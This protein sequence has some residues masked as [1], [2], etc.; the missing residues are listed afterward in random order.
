MRIRIFSLPLVALLLSVASFAQDKPA[1]TVANTTANPVPTKIVNTTP[2]AVTGTVQVGNPNVNVINTPNVNVANSPTVNVGS[3][4]A[5]DLAAGAKVTL[6]TSAGP[7][8][9]RSLGDG[10]RSKVVR[11]A[12]YINL[13]TELAGSFTDLSLSGE[14]GA[15]AYVVPDGKR[16]VVQQWSGRAQVQLGEKAELGLANYSCG[17]TISQTWFLPVQLSIPNGALT[18]VYRGTDH[19]TI[20]VDAGWRLTATFS[21]TQVVRAGNATAR[22]NVSGYLVDCGPNECQS[23]CP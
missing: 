14:Q 10:A 19:G 6:D 7:I 20:Y 22:M 2:L 12:G 18:D 15:A 8:T 16:L 11:L 5:I 1:F 9:V 21:R 4:P 3:L 23:E 17:G 13:T